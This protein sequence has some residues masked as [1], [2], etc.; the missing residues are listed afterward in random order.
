MINLLA[1]QI[2]TLLIG[3]IVIFFQKGNHLSDIFFPVM[4]VYRILLWGTVF[5]GLVFLLDWVVSRNVPEDVVDD[6]GMNE[7]LFKNRTLLEIALLCLFISASE[8]LLFRGAVQYGIGNYW[9]SIVF[10][11]L[12]FRYL[13]HW[14]MTGLVFSISYGLGWLY[15]HTGSLLTPILAHFIIDFIM[16]SIIRLRRKP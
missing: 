7:R 15:I 11:T 14:L 3:L 12:H 13:R 8:E 10:A 4:P 1:T 16:G 6:G 9:T 5:A 2:I